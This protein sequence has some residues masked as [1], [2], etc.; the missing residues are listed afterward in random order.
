MAIN[1]QIP[2]GEWKNF[3]VTFSN[4]NRGRMLSLEVLDAEA[5]DS[6]QARQGKLMSVAYDPV[7]KG[8]DIVVTT[9]EDEVG[10][11]HTID[12]PVEVWK[13]QHENGQIAALE[14]I[15]QNQTKT[16]LSLATN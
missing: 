4:G 16:I 7:G 8:N 10:Y 1:T 5:G 12:A 11:S 2:Q 3:F 13:A 14:I 9:G 15:D 6:G